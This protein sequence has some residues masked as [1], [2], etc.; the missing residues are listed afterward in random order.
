M[1][2]VRIAGQKVSLVDVSVEKFHEIHSIQQHVSDLEESSESDDT[3]K[4]SD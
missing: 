2:E 4:E 3:F 1:F